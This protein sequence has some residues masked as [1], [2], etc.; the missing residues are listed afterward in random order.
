MNG[1][2]H[3]ESI[4]DKNSCKHFFD[5]SFYLLLFMVYNNDY[6]INTY[7]SHNQLQAQ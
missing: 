7:F 6:V 3:S 1:E 4:L 2:F 5:F